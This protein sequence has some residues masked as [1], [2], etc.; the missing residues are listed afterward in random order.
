MATI[1]EMIRQANADGY[2]DE[3][4]E[5]KVCIK[6]RASGRRFRARSGICGHLRAST[7]EEEATQGRRSVRGGAGFRVC[8][9]L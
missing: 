4:A 7:H 3:N 2:M 8:G 1:R 6:Q 5:A 9:A